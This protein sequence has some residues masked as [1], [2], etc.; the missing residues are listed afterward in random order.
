MTGVRRM[1][2]GVASRSMTAAARTAAL[3]ARGMDPW[4]HVPVM[5]IR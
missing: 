3:S 1:G 4:P 5:W 2:P